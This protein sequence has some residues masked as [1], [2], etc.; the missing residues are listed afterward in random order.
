[1]DIV[2]FEDMT[3]KKSGGF[4]KPFQNGSFD[5]RGDRKEGRTDMH[6][7]TC[8]TCGRACEVPFRPTG[9]R[10]VYCRDCFGKK[11]GNT[12]GGDRFSKKEFT[13][14]VSIKPQSENRGGGDNV[15]RQLE[16]VNA[17]LERLIQ[18]VETLSIS[19]HAEAVEETKELSTTKNKKGSKKKAVKK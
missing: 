15:T 13:A 5:G 7:A 9:D 19:N 18:V 3:F 12:G 4:K 14:P 17:K 11:S 1:M 2:Y 16:L 6:P 8:A 10:P